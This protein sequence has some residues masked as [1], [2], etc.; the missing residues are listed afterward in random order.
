MS[1]ETQTVAL[2]QPRAVG[3]G[4]KWEGS[5]RGRGLTHVEVWQQK[6]KLHK[7][8]ILQLKNKKRKHNSPDTGSNVS[9]D[10]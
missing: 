3:W 8:I 5:S 1:Q 10:R 2:Y 9:T 4:G 6:T 7:A